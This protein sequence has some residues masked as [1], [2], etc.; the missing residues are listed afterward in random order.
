MLPKAKFPDIK[1]AILQSDSLDTE[2]GLKGVDLMQNPLNYISNAIE[3]V[4]LTKK[5]A[6]HSIQDLKKKGIQLAINLCDGMIDE[7]KVG[8]EAEDFLETFRIASTGSSAKF[9]RLT[10]E[11]MKMAFVYN[12]IPTPYYFFAFDD[13]ELDL[14]LKNFKKFPAIVKHHNGY[15]SVGM[16]PSSK[17]T[18]A[19]EL[20][21]EVRNCTFKVTYCCFK[22]Q[23]ILQEYG[24][25]MIE[26]F[27]E[28]KEFSMLLAENAHDPK[29]PIALQPIE[30]IFPPG[31]S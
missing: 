19:E 21:K 3:T 8:V 17:V 2:T 11:N 18:N 29:H 5:N 27:I 31:E 30:V 25:V 20:K 13:D 24:G 16:A 12:N 26:E 23:R 6:Y 9:W 15:S 7:D 4:V 28:G 10:K 14:A 1:I 22:G